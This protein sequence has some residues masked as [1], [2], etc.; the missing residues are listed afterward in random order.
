MDWWDHTHTNNSRILTFNTTYYF[1]GGKMYKKGCKR[2]LAPWDIFEVVHKDTQCFKIGKNIHL[3][4]KYI[5]WISRNFARWQKRR[6]FRWY[7][8]S[9]TAIQKDFAGINFREQPKFRESLYP[10]KCIDY[11]IT[12]RTTRVSENIVRDRR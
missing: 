3:L 2:I 5:C 6:K 7:K 10:R 9:R 8:L 4:G 11:Y 12:Y 1:G